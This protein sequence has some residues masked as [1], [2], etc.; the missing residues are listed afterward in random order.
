MMK[1]EILD[2]NITTTAAITIWQPYAILIAIGAKRYETRSWKTSYRG[3]IFIHAAKKWDAE[4]ADDYS[5]VIDV[6][7][8]Y[9]FNRR[10]ANWTNIGQMPMEDLLGSVVAVATLATC[11]PTKSLGFVGL[12]PGQR[13]QR[14]MEH[15][16]GDFRFGRYAWDL[17]NIQA[18]PIPVPCK[19]AQGIW[20]P[21]D[22]VVKQVMD[23]L[24]TEAAQ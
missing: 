13:R 11:L 23:L 20:R 16:L 1:P 6:L 19:G 22:E 9:S 8:D 15:L 5:R 10:L 2:R 7:N 3:R 21:S 18:L 14:E 24:Q 17:Q 4:R 12:S